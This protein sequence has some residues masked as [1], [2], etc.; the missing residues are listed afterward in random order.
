MTIVL[1]IIVVGLGAVVVAMSVRALRTIS[2]FL[3]TKSM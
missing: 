1:V 3:N 2:R